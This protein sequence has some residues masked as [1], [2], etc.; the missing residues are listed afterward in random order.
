[1]PSAIWKPTGKHR[2]QG[3]HGILEDHG[4][5]VAAYLLHGL[6]ALLKEVLALIIDAAGGYYARRIG[7]EAHNGESR[8]RLAGAGLSHQAKGLALFKHEGEVLHGMHDAVLRA[9]L[10]TERPLIC[11]IFSA[12]ALPP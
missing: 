11:K 5:L 9:V 6:F 10:Y 2:V 7:H 1:M 3:G 4:H 8:R 12:M